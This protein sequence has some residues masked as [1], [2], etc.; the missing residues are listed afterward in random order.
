MNSF[1]DPA[2]YLKFSAPRLEPALDLL[3]RID[4]EAPLNV[5]DLGCGAGAVT[6]IIAE[7]WPSANV[8]GV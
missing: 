4:I 2:Q 8:T 7:R 6:R 5:F 1:W 3:A